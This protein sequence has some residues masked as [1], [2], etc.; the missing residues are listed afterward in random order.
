M[1]K[2]GRVVRP[3][4]TPTPPPPKPKH[5]YHYRHHW[6]YWHHYNWYDND[7]DW[8]D[9]NYDWSD[10]D[11]DSED[12]SFYS[13]PNKPKMSRHT[14]DYSN[15][16]DWSAYVMSAYQQ[17]FKDGWYAAFEYMN[18]SEG[19]STWTPEPSPTPEPKPTPEPPKPP[20]TELK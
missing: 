7:Y 1:K 3:T 6:P 11:Y 16:N 9:S 10:S 14:N 19:T 13:A 4:P 18:S 17:G 2:P 12:W 5:W 15:N 8:Y 20:M